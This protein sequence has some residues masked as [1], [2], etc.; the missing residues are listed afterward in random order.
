[1]R[2]KKSHL[3]SP[4]DSGHVNPIPF[5]QSIY[6]MA[7]RNHQAICNKRSLAQVKKCYPINL[8]YTRL[9][10]GRGDHPFCGAGPPGVGKRVGVWITGTKVQ[11]TI[12]YLRLEPSPKSWRHVC[13]STY[14]AS[15]I[16]KPRSLMKNV[17]YTV[18]TPVRGRG[19]AECMH[20][21]QSPDSRFLVAT[22]PSPTALFIFPLLTTSTCTRITVKLPH[23]GV[24]ILEGSPR[25][26]MADMPISLDW[27]LPSKSF[28]SVQRVHGYRNYG[29]RQSVGELGRVV[30]FMRFTADFM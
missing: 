11:Q 28:S 20:H 3:A 8:G 12:S 5:M 27:V 1:M 7:I 4:G 6:G 2:L 29:C 18:H 17:Y 14:T 21:G 19:M 15:E 9:V 22:H 25:H 13:H 10:M 16:E 26:K 24:D 23:T 30:S